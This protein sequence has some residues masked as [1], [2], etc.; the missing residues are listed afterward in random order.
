MTNQPNNAWASSDADAPV[1]KIDDNPIVLAPVFSTSVQTFTDTLVF[2]IASSQPDAEIFYSLFDIDNPIGGFQWRQG[3]RVVLTESKIVKAYA[4]LPSRE[5]SAI[6]E[7]KFIKVKNVKGISIKGTCS[8]LYPGGGDLGLVDGLR[9][10]TNFRVGGWH[11]YQNQDFE[12]VIDLGEAKEVSYVGANFLQDV[13]PWIMMP[14]M[15]TYS[16]SNDNVN[17]TTI[18]VVTNTV[19]DKEQNPTIKEFGL[20]V[21]TKA[22]YVKVFAKSYGELPADH[23][24]AGEPSWIF[25][26]EIVVR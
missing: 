24:S 18:G 26:D 20:D 9:G 3:S 7:G 6:I 8:S 16:T 14:K 23:I 2:N 22:R 4:V 25:I 21:R 12:A 15:V 13:G 17:F 5:V 10:I 19:S 11:G 1:T